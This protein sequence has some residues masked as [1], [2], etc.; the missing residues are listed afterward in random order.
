MTPR[1]LFW[2]RIEESE[3][4]RA[5]PDRWWLVRRDLPG[6]RR[7]WLMPMLYGNLRL[8]TGPAEGLSFDDGWC[9]HD[10]DAAWRAALEWSG[11]GEPDGWVRHVFSGRRR[12]EGDA[13][14][15]Y[16]NP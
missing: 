2:T 12:P 16:V 3:A 11:E 5:D 4:F 6:G 7:L 10:H 1:E 15:E 9:Y 8:A 14:R 13:A